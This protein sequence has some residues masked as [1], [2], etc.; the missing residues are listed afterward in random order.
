MHNFILFSVSF[1]SFPSLHASISEMRD[2]SQILQ[3][4]FYSMKNQTMESVGLRN[5]VITRE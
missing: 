5:T 3:A 1:P 4:T 2:R